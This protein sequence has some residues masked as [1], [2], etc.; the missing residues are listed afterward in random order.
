MLPRRGPVAAFALALLVTAP[1]AT[2]RGRALAGEDAARVAAAEAFLRAPRE[3][4]GPRVVVV[5]R[6]DCAY[7]RGL[8]ADVLSDARVQAALD[9]AGAI[10]MWGPGDARARALGMVG[11]PTL[12]VLGRDG[13]LRGGLLEGY[14]G[15]PAAYAAALEARL[16]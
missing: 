14:H 12:A 13:Q 5:L 3:R 7:C 11:P 9:R 6:E 2:A 8:L 1:L 10:D 16:R 15:D 4:L